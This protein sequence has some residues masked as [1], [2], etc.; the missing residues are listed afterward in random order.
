MALDDLPRAPPVFALQKT[1]QSHTSAMMAPAPDA[2]KMAAHN[3]VRVAL[4]TKA[5]PYECRSKTVQQC[6]N[7][8]PVRSG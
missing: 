1:R 7:L 4:L 2:P 5:L 8:R 6:R 3:G